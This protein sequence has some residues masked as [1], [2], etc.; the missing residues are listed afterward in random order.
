MRRISQ[1]P[2]LIFMMLLVY[3]FRRRWA[4]LEIALM[5]IGGKWLIERMDRLDA[6]I[7]E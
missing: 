7:D 4:L 6:E 5:L 2:L 3:L 1:W